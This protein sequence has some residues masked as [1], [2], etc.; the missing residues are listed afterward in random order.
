MIREAWHT[1]LFNEQSV[2]N[3]SV[4]QNVCYKM[5]SSMITAHRIEL[6][7]ASLNPTDSITSLR[8]YCI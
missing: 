8:V 1:S 4:E 7:G 5:N 6:N 3:S 2:L